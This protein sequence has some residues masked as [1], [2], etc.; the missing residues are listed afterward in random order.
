MIDRQSL[1]GVSNK[2]GESD[3]AQLHIPPFT[4]P[5]GEKNP[6]IFRFVVSREVEAVFLI[7]STESKNA[8]KVQSS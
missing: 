7:K 1:S 4:W 2:V 6:E 3:A 8:D 5:G